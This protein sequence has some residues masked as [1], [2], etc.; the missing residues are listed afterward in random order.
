MA[1]EEKA[2]KRHAES[3]ALGRNRG[4]RRK[5]QEVSVRHEASD[6]PYVTKSEPPSRLYGFLS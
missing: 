6:V 3:E 4:K 5:S 1:S 2:A